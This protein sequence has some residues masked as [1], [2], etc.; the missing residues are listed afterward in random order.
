MTMY[1]CPECG[2]KRIVWWDARAKAFLCGARDPACGFSV[3]TPAGQ[4]TCGDDRGHVAKLLSMGHA[5]VT[6]M[7]MAEQGG[8]TCPS[9]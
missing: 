3:R 5:N 2:R 1:D 9:Q 7:W 6:L 8:A 4:C